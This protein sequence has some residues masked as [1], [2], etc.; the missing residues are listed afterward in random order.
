MKVLKPHPWQVSIH[1]AAEIQNRL[2][3]EIVISPINFESI[4]Y[5]AGADVS[6]SKYS[7]DVFAAVVILSYPELSVIEEATASIKTSF[8]YVPGYLTF[9]EGPA[10]V[11]AFE[12]IRVEPDVIIF[13]GQGMAHPRGF[14]I[15]SHMGVLLD[16]PSVGCAKSVLIGK[17]KEPAIT[18]GSTS[19]LLDKN[20]RQIGVALRTRDN[21]SPVFVSIGNRISLEDSVKVV[22][23]C[24]PRY[25]LP[26]PIRRAHSLSNKIRKELLH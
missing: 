20:G 9:R 16:R 10:L 26:E 13:D 15:A 24:A 23:S 7:D 8:P 6:F 11:V 5:V 14:G 2:R 12:K 1:E 17:Y 18:R 3:Q 21:V 19:P 4:N 22:L 25:R